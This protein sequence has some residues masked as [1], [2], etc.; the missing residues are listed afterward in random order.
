MIYAKC[1]SN[2]KIN[3]VH[4]LHDN[5]IINVTKMTQLD[6]RYNE[7]KELLLEKR[8][9][10]LI[11]KINNPRKKNSLTIKAYIEFAKVLQLA[12]EDESVAVVAVTGTGDVYT[13]GNDLS[14]SMSGITDFDEFLLDTDVI[15]K[16]LIRSFYE[17]PKI[18]VAVV[19]GPCIGIGM[20]TA[21]LCDI[22]YCTDNAYF[23]TPFTKLGLCPEGC[24]S[25]TFPRLL[26]KAKSIEVLLLNQK[27]TATEALRLNFVADVV[28]PQELDTK[29]W[30]KIMDIT[31]LPLG[32]LMAGKALLMKAHNK[33]LESAL[34]EEC[35]ELQ[36][37]FRSDEFFNALAAF[38]QRKS[39]KL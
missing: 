10:L 6:K 15:L 18:L 13:S 21:A 27:L 35:A 19:N 4:F 2:S 28:K 31:R 20:T 11:I 39:S 7:F 12:G 38:G 22:I 24:S 5:K 30:P 9:K 37:R 1:R 29:I 26:G 23:L 33:D 17:F 25:H 36:K 34:I 8:E 16:N 3:C 32:S 14:L